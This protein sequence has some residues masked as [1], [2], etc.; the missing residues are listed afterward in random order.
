VYGDVPATL[1]YER[2]VLRGC[3]SRSTA[4][5]ASFLFAAAGDGMARFIHVRRYRNRP[6]QAVFSGV[7]CRRRHTNHTAEVRRSRRRSPYERTRE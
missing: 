4:Q 5:G 7:R 6:Q 3:R 1:V 2:L